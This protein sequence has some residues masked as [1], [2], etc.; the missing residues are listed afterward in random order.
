LQTTSQNLVIPASKN[1]DSEKLRVTF[2]IANGGVMAG[3]KSSILLVSAAIAMWSVSATPARPAD[4]NA[5]PDLGPFSTQLDGWAGGFFIANP[6]GNAVPDENNLLAYGADARLR[7]DLAEL[8][9]VQ[10][11]ASVDDTDKNVGFGFYQGGWQAAGHLNWTD[12]EAGLLG[13]FGGIGSGV[14]QANGADGPDGNDFSL[15]GVEGQIYFDS[16]TLYLQAG[17]FNARNEFFANDAF[18]DAWFG[19]TVGRY[20]LSPETRLQAEVSY[21]HGKQDGGDLNMDIVGWGA[22][23]DHQLF[24]N[25]ALFAAYD[26]GYYANKDVVGSDD[27]SYVEH[28]VRSGISISLGQPD[29]LTTDRHGPNLDMPRVTHW[30][31]SGGILD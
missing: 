9:S 28:L 22:R 27:G 24:E 8:I 26:G 19:R 13:V 15:A 10:A 25:V 6:K 11:E 17:Y 29:L 5:E 18:H 2:P 14:S 20:F 4:V 31:A 7:L 3:F 21:A 23:V 30:A 12:G 1:I 16:A